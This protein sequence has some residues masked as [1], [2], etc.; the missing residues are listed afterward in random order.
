MSGFSGVPGWSEDRNSEQVFN[1]VCLGRVRR[2][3]V[4]IGRLSRED[5]AVLLFIV[6]KIGGIFVPHWNDLVQRRN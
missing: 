4:A 2:I 5:F 3:L 6:L 1:S